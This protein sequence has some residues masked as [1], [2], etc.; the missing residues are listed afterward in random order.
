MK[1]IKL[2]VIFIYITPFAVNIPIGLTYN[3]TSSMPEGWYLLYPPVNLKIGDTVL[4]CVPLNSESLQGIKRTYIYHSAKYKFS[5]PD[6]T[7]YVIKRLT[8]LPFQTVILS[9]NGIK[10]NNNFT[11]YHVL[12]RS[13]KPANVP[14]K[15][16]PY[17]KYKVAGY[18][19]ISTYNPLSYDSRYWGYV[20]N[21][22]YKAAYIGKNL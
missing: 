20:K 15:H 5:C 10:V 11:K 16:F 17:G 9:A 19:L 2:I 8:S 4:A 14:I 22:Q 18:F 13:L 21:I 6:N 1:I 12:L 7:I 3:Y